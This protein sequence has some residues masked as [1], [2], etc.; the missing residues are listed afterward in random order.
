MGIEEVKTL[1]KDGD[2]EGAWEEA[3]KLP[4]GPEESFWKGLCIADPREINWADQNK[5]KAL[6]FFIE[7][8]ADGA[9]AL[10][11][12]YPALVLRGWSK[13]C[14]AKMTNKDTIK[15]DLSAG[16]QDISDAIGNLLPSFESFAF[17]YMACVNYLLMDYAKNP[18]EE[19]EY[20]KNAIKDLK[21]AMDED[22]CW[23]DKGAKEITPWIEPYANMVAIIEE[24][25]F[26]KKDRKKHERKISGTYWKNFIK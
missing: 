20:Y 9:Q 15:D 19:K 17:N 11:H 22:P 8:T 1:F 10:P 2:T 23:D 13:A 25:V 14:V 18:D 16:L 6:Q 21:R 4:P 5:Q 3:K 7:A 26:T 12:Y 24:M